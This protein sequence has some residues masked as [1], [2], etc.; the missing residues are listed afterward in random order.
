VVFAAT[1]L[2]FVE[3]IQIWNPGRRLTIYQSPR[4]NGKHMPVR[5]LPPHMYTR[6][7]R[8]SAENFSGLC[9]LLQL[10]SNQ[11]FI[12]AYSVESHVLAGHRIFQRPCIYS[13]VEDCLMAQPSSK[14]NLCL[15][16]KRNAAIFDQ[17][18]VA[19]GDNGPG[20]SGVS[21]Q[22]ICAYKGEFL[23]QGKILR[24]ESRG[25]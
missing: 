2:C 22:W 1:A 5:L 13:E 14:T 16:H 12:V 7:R 21:F 11:K 8:Q 3:T 6:V 24:L 15:S 20:S 9:T 10:L 17:Y 23:R 4:E 25:V 18:Y 19:F